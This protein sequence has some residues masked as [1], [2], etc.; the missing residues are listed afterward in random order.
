[1]RCK[2]DS[3][4][5]VWHTW[6]QRLNILMQMH[7]NRQALLLHNIAVWVWHLS[8][9]KC[10][11]LCKGQTRKCA[12]IKNIT[13]RLNSHYFTRYLLS[14][15]RMKCCD[16]IWYHLSYALFI[17]MNL[18]LPVQTWTWL[19]QIF[20]SRF[21]QTQAESHFNHDFDSLGMFFRSKIWY[22]N[23]TKR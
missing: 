9:L 23:W 3:C 11:I 5:L 20:F 1:M 21:F 14:M 19:H 8:K 13:L 4:P 2:H 16:S 12:Q 10:K 6:V 7:V 15:L 22:R 18:V 17:S